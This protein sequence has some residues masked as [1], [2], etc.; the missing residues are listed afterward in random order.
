MDRRDTVLAL[1]ALGAHP[2]IA[3]AQ[4]AAKVARIGY[5]SAG[6]TSEPQLRDAFVQGLRDLGYV[7]GRNIILEFRFARGDH[8]RGPQLA[9]ELVALPVDVIVVEGLSAA[10]DL[11]RTVPVVA[12]V[13]VDPVKSGRAANLARPGRNVTGFTLMTTELN[14]KRVELLHDAFRLSPR[15]PSSSTLQT[16]QINRLSSRLKRPPGRWVWGMSAGSRPRA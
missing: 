14:G 5:L 9:A 7:E 16:R 6:L 12:P 1:L 13:M 4:Q 8:T 3:E 10:I 15:S 11:N 2:L